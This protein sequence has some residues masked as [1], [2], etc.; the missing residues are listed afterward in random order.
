MG[1]MAAYFEEL[2]FD[3]TYGNKDM[4]ICKRVAYEPYLYATNGP[5]EFHYSEIEFLK[6]KFVVHPETQSVHAPLPLELIMD[7]TNWCTTSLPITE[8]TSASCMGAIQELYHH[9][10]KVFAEN[11]KLIFT[12]LRRA[13]VPFPRI[14]YN[15]LYARFH[16]MSTNFK[17]PQ[18]ITGVY[19]VIQ[20]NTR[21]HILPPIC[22]SKDEILQ[23]RT[24]PPRPQVTPRLNTL[25]QLLG[26]IFPQMPNGRVDL[27]RAHEIIPNLQHRA[28]MRIDHQPRIEKLSVCI[29]ILLNFLFA[30]LI[31]SAMIF[32]FKQSFGLSENYPFSQMKA[33]QTMKSERGIVSGVTEGASIIAY[34]I[35][36]LPIVGS[37][38]S[39]AAPILSALSSFAKTL[40]YDYPSNTS[41]TNRFLTNQISSIAS[42]KGLD[43]V[44]QL[45]FDP[46]NQVSNDPS[47]FCEVNGPSNLFKNYKLRPGLIATVNYTG[48]ESQNNVV[49]ALPVAPTYCTQSVTANYYAI[50]PI[51]NYASN[52]RYWR[53][54]MKYKLYFTC[55]RFISSRVRIEWVPDPTIISSITNEDSGDIVSLTV[56]VCGDT[57]VSFTVPYLRNQP[58][59][60]VADPYTLQLSQSSA[61]PF[62]N[63]FFVIRIINPPLTNN[64]TYSSNVDVAIFMSGGE[65]FQVARP[66]QL[67]TNYVYTP[68]ISLTKNKKEIPV[69]QGK[70]TLQEEFTMTFK[71]LSDAHQS[72]T[73]GLLQGEE[74]VSWTE[75]FHRYSL[76]QNI[77]DSA[78]TIMNFSFNPWTPYNYGYP[79]TLFNVFMHS[80]MFQRGNFRY[81]ALSQDSDYMCAMSLSNYI[82]TPEGPAEDD[83]HTWADR[84]GMTWQLATFRGA[85]EAEI[86]FYGVFP[87]ACTQF[88]TLE[89]YELPCVNFTT[90][91]RDGV[92]FAHN[93]NLFIGTGDNFS[94]GQPSPPGYF[95]YVTPL[96]RKRIKGFKIPSIQ[97][98]KNSELTDRQ[99]VEVQVQETKELTSFRDTVTAKTT[100]NAQITKAHNHSDPYPDQGMKA[101]LSRPYLTAN[102]TWSGTQFT[103]AL[104]YSGYYPSDLMVSPN[105]IEKLS[106][107]KYFR[108]AVKVE[109]RLN[110]TSFHSGKLLVVYAPHW[111]PNSTYGS[112]NNADMYCLAGHF[113]TILVSANSNETI[114]FE[115]PYCAPSSYFDLSLDPTATDYTGFFGTYQIYVL[116]PLTLISSPTAPSLDLTVYSSFVDPEVAGFTTVIPTITEDRSKSKK[117]GCTVPKTTIFKID[118]NYNS[119]K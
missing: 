90:Y 7:M 35:S 21:K 115:I 27:S 88:N 117:K 52:F 63:G 95:E 89:L 76:I 49:T 80:F 51:A 111:N 14:T 15:D 38:A 101:V 108:S 83:S 48:A 93:Y 33:E 2:N 31:V 119:Q 36:S 19:P 91:Q 104:L 53:G 25:Q 70:T 79:N 28:N 85:T 109:M 94:V 32:T 81:K 102:I 43:T 87:F 69:V 78:S 110:S 12:E 55:S 99:V 105:I 116:S 74:I 57:D 42:G 29:G 1:A 82:V 4:V 10:P 8:A 112:G 61:T 77:T 13:N 22:G 96:L 5:Q 9:G 113:E 17:P 118:P 44:E 20:G 56:D 86:P 50:H 59:L 18:Y 39:K 24:I 47:L 34:S 71:P 11:S 46:A 30:Y 114:S 64:S 68:G 98:Q 54:S 97:M 66:T 72:V 73:E 107:F 60:V 16:G 92:A 40:G 62:S 75:L 100:M 45:G 23:V 3:Y 26:D 106:K 67:W 84:Q 41:S 37:V 103:G 58:W 6:R 65:D